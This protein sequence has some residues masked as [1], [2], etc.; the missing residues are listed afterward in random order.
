MLYRNQTC[1]NNF[2]I[3]HNI[4]IIGGTKGLLGKLKTYETVTR[5]YTSMV[6]SGYLFRNSIKIW[7]N[8]QFVAFFCIT[9][10]N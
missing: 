5:R 2:N 7:Q 1:R 9:S 3:L 8:E 4:S 10:I 6:F